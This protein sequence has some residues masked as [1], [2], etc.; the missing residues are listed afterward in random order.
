MTQGNDR[1]EQLTEWAATKLPSD[2]ASAVLSMVAVQ[3][4]KADE[5]RL[6]TEFL[7]GL[8][9]LAPDSRRPILRHMLAWA[10]SQP[11]SHL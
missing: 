11:K 6:V 7:E 8:A 3:L 9:S 1:I 10:D 4:A 5:L 2:E